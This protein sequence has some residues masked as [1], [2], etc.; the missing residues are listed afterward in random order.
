MKA[1]G[2]ENSEAA[3]YFLNTFMISENKTARKLHKTVIANQLGLTGEICEQ[4]DSTKYDKVIDNLLEA[5]MT[6]VVMVQSPLSILL[7]SE[8][9]AKIRAQIRGTAANVS[10]LDLAINTTVNSIK[11]GFTKLC[12]LKKNVDCKQEINKFS[13]EAL[14]SMA[15]ITNALTVAITIYEYEAKIASQDK[16]HQQ[17]I[18]KLTAQGDQL[19][20]TSMPPSSAAILLASQQPLIKNASTAVN[21]EECKLQPFTG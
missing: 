18:A 8:Q 21:D 10:S 9:V 15:K 13:A 7:A 16:E 17:Q 11:T 20:A 6:L 5:F 3:Q 2:K 12:N 1:T 19:K 14:L 4:F